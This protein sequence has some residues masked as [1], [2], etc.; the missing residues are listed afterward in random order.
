M[1]SS[2]LAACSAPEGEMVSDLGALRAM[3]P[4]KIS[5]AEKKVPLNQME[6]IMLIQKTDMTKV[7]ATS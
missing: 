5:S 3:E 1:L 7:E 6:V 4:L 2:K